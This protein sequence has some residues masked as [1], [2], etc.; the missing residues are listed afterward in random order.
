VGAS[1]GSGTLTVEIHLTQKKGAS[2]PWSIVPDTVNVVNG[3]LVVFEVRNDGT[4]VH[5]LMLGAP[6]NIVTPPLL[7]TQKATLGP[8]QANLSAGETSLMVPYWCSIPG[9]KMLGMEGMMMV[10]AD[11]NATNATVPSGAKP[12][13]GAGP[14]GPSGSDLLLAVGAAAGAVA[15][16]A[17]LSRVR[18]R[19]RGW[20]APRQP[21]SP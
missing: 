12:A 7:P 3:T 20:V 9:H 8:I 19:R 10:A 1:G 18:A 4:D 6:Y 17:V 14:A 13:A 2:G 21:K 11:A 5:T 15:A 16:F